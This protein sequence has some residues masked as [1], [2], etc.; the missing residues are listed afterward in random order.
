MSSAEQRIAQV[1]ED[2]HEPDEVELLVRAREVVD[3]HPAELDAVLRARTAAAAQRGLREVVRVDVDA[4]HRWRRAG[5]ARS[6]RSRRCSRCRAR[7]S[8]PGRAGRCGAIW[9]HLNAGKV[10][11]EEVVGRRLR[12]VRQVQVVEPRARARAISPLQLAL[13]ALGRCRRSWRPSCQHRTATTEPISRGSSSASGTP[14]SSAARCAAVCS[15]RTPPA[16]RS[17]IRTALL[18]RPCRAAAAS[19]SVGVGAPARSR[20]RART[21]SRARPAVADDRRAAGRRLEQPHAG[22]PAGGDHVGA[23]D[24]QREALRCRSRGARRG[25]RCSMRS[26][27]AGQRDVGRILR[28]GDDEAAC[29]PA[30]RR[31]QQQA[32]ERRL[33]VV[34]VGAHVAEV[35]AHGGCGSG[36][37]S[38]GSTEQ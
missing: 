20:A 2:A 27:L 36:K 23:G 34:A 35:P 25:G 15:A 31:L 11:A 6:C 37:Y 26:T 24:V 32:L 16:R 1:V 4:E 28:A 10:A 17:P 13:A 14:P 12:A 29:R 22:R 5:P 3:L 33:A 8:R 18:L 30:A 9:R 19:T 7:A 21:A 38:V